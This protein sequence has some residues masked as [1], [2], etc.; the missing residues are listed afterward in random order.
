MQK[1]LFFYG[2][3][4]VLFGISILHIMNSMQY[5]VTSRKHEFGIMRAMGI[6]DI[7]FCK[8]LIKEG[9]RY[10]LYS[11]LVLTI[12]Y[13]IVQKVLYYFMAHVYLYLHPSGFISWLPF[14][15]VLTLNIV[16]CILVVLVSGRTVLKEEII[17]E[18]R[19]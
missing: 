14:V 9:L 8:M 18:I 15:S 7:G 10:G 5:L 16:I 1:M 4:A 13:M 12:L 11:G 3:A 2:I 6:T 17:D 19:E